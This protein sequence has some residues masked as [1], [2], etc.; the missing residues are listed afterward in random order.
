MLSCSRTK[1]KIRSSAHAHTMTVV[2]VRAKGM[3][4]IDSRTPIAYP[5]T[6]AMAVPRRRHIALALVAASKQ[7]ADLTSPAQLI[8][9][10]GKIAVAMPAVP[11]GH[12]TREWLAAHDLLDTLEARFVLAR[13]V[14]ATL[15]LVESGAADF[16]FVYVSD[17]QGAAGLELVWSTG[18]GE[19]PRI[20]YHG[21]C[22]AGAS[23]AALEFL[24]WLSGP[25]FQAAAEQGGFTRWQP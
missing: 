25:D 2:L 15:A 11:A 18:A 24:D 9:A 1:P 17:L 4:A 21:A 20:A 16:G 8:E 3:P 12:Y 5:L 14:R 19:A 23:A 22:L 13:N 10:S 6:M 7:T